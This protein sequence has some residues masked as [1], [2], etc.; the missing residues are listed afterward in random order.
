MFASFFYLLLIF[1][2]GLFR[3]ETP[4]TLGAS[5]NIYPACLNDRGIYI[6]QDEVIISGYGHIK[7]KKVTQRNSVLDFDST[8]TVELRFGRFKFRKNDEFNIGCSYANETATCSGILSI[9]KESF[10]STLT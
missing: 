10:I 4:F 7:T 5:S 1:L 6:I 2:K 3:V 8:P 9:E